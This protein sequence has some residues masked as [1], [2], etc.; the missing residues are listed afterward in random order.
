MNTGLK[1]RGE[2]ALE[3]FEATMQQYHEEGWK[4]SINVHE[5][6]SAAVSA[7]KSGKNP[8]MKTL[9]RGHG[10]S[11]GWLHERAEQGDYV[12]V[13]TRSEDMSADIYTKSIM[14]AKTWNTLRKLLEDS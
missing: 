3:I 6:N 8:T 13:P 7:V 14:D 12:I 11:I 9:E 1:T 5:D 4:V 2:P 10:V